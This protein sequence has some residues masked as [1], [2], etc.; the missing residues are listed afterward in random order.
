MSDLINM[1]YN[2]IRNGKFYRSLVKLVVIQKGNSMEKGQKKRKN[3]KIVTIILLFAV[4]VGCAW[5][6]NLG[7]ARIR[8]QASSTVELPTQA[9]DSDSNVLVVY[10]T[11]AENSDVDAVSSASVTV[12]DGVAKGNVRAVADEIAAYT[13]GDLFSIQTSVKY[14]GN[15]N[16]LIDYAQNEQNENARPELTTHIEN[17]DKYDTVFI[18][19]PTWWY[20]LPQVMYSF[21][22]EYDFSGKTI[23]PF[24]SANGSR[25]SGTIETIQN[26]EPNATVITDGLSVHQRDV[27][28]SKQEVEVWLKGLGL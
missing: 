23:I 3:D 18:G 24:N 12:V 9:L 14:S 15:V 13:G 20:D 7:G 2:L 8:L 17:L 19:Y 27:S 1:S 10:F 16:S 11:A 26:L 25:F 22:D 6:F 21:F 28:N 4:V 5:Y